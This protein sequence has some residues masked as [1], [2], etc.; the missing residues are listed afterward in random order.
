[1]LS[2]RQ[3]SKTAKSISFQSQIGATEA[4]IH[5]VAGEI[6]LLSPNSDAANAEAHRAALRAFLW[7]HTWIDHFDQLCPIC[8]SRDQLLRRFL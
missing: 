1:L 6:A 3:T 4:D 5:R 7:D 8:L 2:E